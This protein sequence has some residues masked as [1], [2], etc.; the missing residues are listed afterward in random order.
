MGWHHYWAA[1]PLGLG[2]PL[3][4]YICIHPV[5]NT[6]NN[7]HSYMVSKLGFDFPSLPPHNRRPPL[8][9]P[10]APAS[11]CCLREAHPSLLGRPPSQSP[12]FPPLSSARPH[13][14]AK[15]LH[16]PSICT[17]PCSNPARP[18]STPRVAVTGP[19]PCDHTVRASSALP[20]EL[21]H[22]GASSR[23]TRGHSFHGVRMFSSQ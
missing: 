23:S 9:Q 5:C 17:P 2:F 18:S 16:L 10:L 13:Q 21:G 11:A 3:S 15:V 8:A 14:D 12:V 1:D 7:S 22:A 19:E 6:S 4:L 20:V